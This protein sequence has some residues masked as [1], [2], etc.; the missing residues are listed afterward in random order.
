ML[1]MSGQLHYVINNTRL[2]NRG[3]N[4]VSCKY[5]PLIQHAGWVCELLICADT[6][7]QFICF[8]VADIYI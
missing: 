5:C 1:A 3:L 8:S 2:L 4:D 7:P 6:L